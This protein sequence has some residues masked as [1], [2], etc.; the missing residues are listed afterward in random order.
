MLRKDTQAQSLLVSSPDE[1]N[2]FACLQV[3]CAQ[4][5][6]HSLDVKCDSLGFRYVVSSE[7]VTSSQFD[8]LIR[9]LLITLLLGECARG[10]L[11]TTEAGKS[12]LLPRGVGKLYLSYAE[13]L[14]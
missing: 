9:I 10:C 7:W 1:G 4:Q 11:G 14:Y 2:V 3:G 8:W 5:P 13:K 12:C 6:L